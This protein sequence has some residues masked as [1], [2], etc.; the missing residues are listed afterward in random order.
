MGELGGVQ[1]DSA[2]RD[3]VHISDKRRYASNPKRV[4]TAASRGGGIEKRLDITSEIVCLR[5]P[6]G[7]RPGIW[8]R[9][10][11]SSQRNRNYFWEGECA[12]LREAAANSF[13]TSVSFAPVV[14]PINAS[15]PPLDASVI[16]GGDINADDL[17]SAFSARVVVDIDKNYNRK[18]RQKFIHR[19]VWQLVRDALLVDGVAVPVSVPSDTSK[20]KGGAK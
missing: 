9:R 1:T 17:Q 2:P 11:E 7:E 5:L 18:S 15:Q 6:A 13:A 3:T 14:R 8:E 16:T 10:R 20:Q 19:R 4:T 12:D